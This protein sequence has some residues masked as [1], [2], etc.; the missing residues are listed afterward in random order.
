MSA[1]AN[2]NELEALQAVMAQWV[3][4]FV[5]L[6]PSSSYTFDNKKFTV[7]SPPAPHFMVGIRSADSNQHTLGRAPSRTWRRDA[8]VWVRCRVPQ[9]TGM[10]TLLGIVDDVRRTFEGASFGGVTPAGGTRWETVGSDGQYTEVVVF[11]PVTY[12]DTH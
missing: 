11:S 9:D 2:V 4:E 12:Y 10:G 5:P 3:A 1:D 8:I 6:H 7:P